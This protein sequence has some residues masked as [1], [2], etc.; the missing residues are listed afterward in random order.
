MRALH[1]HLSADL[2]LTHCRK[3]A[4]SH[5]TSN[6][7]GTSY[8]DLYEPDTPSPLSPIEELDDDIFPPQ[9]HRHSS[10]GT[11]DPEDVTITPIEIP[12]KDILHPLEQR[13]ELLFSRQHLQLILADVKLSL[14]FADF[15]RMYRPDSVSI[16]GYYFDS[17][18]ALKTIR[19]AESIIKNLEPIPGHTF[20]AE[21]NSATM[22]WVMEEKADRALDVLMKDDLPA[23]IAYV[24]VRTV[25]VALVDRVI[26]REDPR[27]GGIA[28]GLAEVFV[29]SDPARL[30][31]PIVFTSEGILTWI[32]DR[33][34][35]C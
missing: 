9:K 13:S 17:I 19:Y 35:G 23:F 22:G 10:H 7:L 30:D 26:G 11:L 28:D 4:I 14:K 16:L 12:E 15:L 1:N 32:L 5:S 21:A 18:K 8:A 33:H 3:Q 31:N 29:L 2:L 20:T 27:S 34:R 25:D 24:Y 6:G